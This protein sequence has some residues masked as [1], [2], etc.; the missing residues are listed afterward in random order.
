[1]YAPV[2]NGVR[3][4]R[5]RSGRRPVVDEA[6]RAE[7]SGRGA[8]LAVLARLD[9]PVAVKVDAVRGRGATSTAAVTFVVD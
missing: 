2:V 5:R 1:M 4:R 8:E 9:L 7:H 6:R 3:S